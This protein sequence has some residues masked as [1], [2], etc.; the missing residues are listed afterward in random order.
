MTYTVRNH[1][2]EKDGKEVKF[3]ASPNVG[4]ALKPQYLVMHY[5]AGLTLD[6]AVSWFANPQAKASA[7]ITIG[8]DGSIVQQV[9]FNKVAWHAGKST[10]GSLIGMNSYAIGIELVNAGKLR[11]REDGKWVNWADN[12]VPPPEVTVLTHKNESS[13]AGWHIYAEVQLQTA[14]DVARALNDQYTFLDIVGHDDIS[15]NRKVDPGPAFPM[16]TFESQVMGR[17]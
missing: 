3:V 1:R 8:R 6:G 15:P 4:G 17:T 12:V 14:I 16:I 9:P 5:T 7:H 13:P 11:K 2:L 10:W